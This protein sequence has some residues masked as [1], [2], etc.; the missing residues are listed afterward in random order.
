M[1]CVVCSGPIEEGFRHGL[2]QGKRSIAW[3]AGRNASA[4]QI[5]STCGVLNSMN[6]SKLTTTVE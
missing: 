4:T 3:N 1:P 2:P 6:T 5:P